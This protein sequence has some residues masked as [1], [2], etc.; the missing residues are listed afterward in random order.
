MTKILAIANQKGG[1]GKTTIATQ[2]AFDLALRRKKHVLYIDMDAQGNGSTVLLRGSEINGL[3]AHDLFNPNLNDVVP[4]KTKFENIDIIPTKCNSLASYSMEGLPDT[5]IDDPKKNLA[6]IKDQYDIILI[7][8]PPHL[9]I[10]LRAALTMADAVM[11]PIRLCGFS[12]E[13][14]DGLLS[15]IQQI[16]HTKNPELKL[17]GVLINAFDRSVTQ[18]A[19]L[20]QIYTSM[21][22]IV[23]KNVIR[24]RTPLDTANTYGIPLWEVPSAYRALENLSNAFEEIYEKS[25]IEVPALKTKKSKK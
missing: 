24:N 20:D 14:L 23:M 18:Q 7:D 2:L 5:S 4:H 11:C 13:G 19:V 22:E 17:A 15:T 6:K 3:E 25:D 1:V 10:K 9:G 8:C 12:L 21:S 16:Q